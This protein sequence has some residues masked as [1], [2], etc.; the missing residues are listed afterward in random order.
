MIKYDIVKSEWHPIES[1]ITDWQPVGK[2]QQR[3]GE[4][5][6]MDRSDRSCCLILFCAGWAACAAWG[7]QLGKTPGRRLG[8]SKRR[9]QTSAERGWTV[10]KWNWIHCGAGFFWKR[11]TKCMD[12]LTFKAELWHALPESSN[13]AITSAGQ[14]QGIRLRVLFKGY[15]RTQ[16][17]DLKHLACH[18]QQH[19]KVSFG[20]LQPAQIA[21]LVCFAFIVALISFI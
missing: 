16:L 2:Q 14:Q 20:V 9:C 13:L 19:R 1:S 11:L 7:V 10:S 17:V 5:A 15:F 18:V 8:L 4:T 3:P 21:S 12:T 6:K